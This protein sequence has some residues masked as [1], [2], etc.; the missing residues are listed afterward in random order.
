MIVDYLANH[1]DLLPEIAELVFAEWRELCTVNGIDLDRVR[2]TLAQRAVT[3]RVP[4]T[5][6][7]LEDGQLVAT[8]SIKASEPA[9][10]E[11]LS[12]WLD[13]MYVKSAWRGLGVGRLLLEAMEKKAVDLGFEALYLSTDEAEGF[14]ARHGWTVIEHQRGADGKT[15]AF[16][17]KNLNPSES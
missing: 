13:M 9:T 17:A 1:Q 14:Y 7:V 6:V 10:R 16:M 11:G 8:G 15:V 2:A 4:L 5:L 12:P 3:D